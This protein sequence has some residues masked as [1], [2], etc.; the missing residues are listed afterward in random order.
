MGRPQSKHPF[1]DVA[2]TVNH[3]QPFLCLSVISA[4][5][6][7][8]LYA[9]NGYSLAIAGLWITSLLAGGLHFLSRPA[10]QPTPLVPAKSDLWLLALLLVIFA[11]FYLLFLYDLPVQLN[12]DE[13]HVLNMAKNPSVD[14][15]FDL[16]GLSSHFGNPNLIFYLVGS[17]ADGLGAMHWLQ[18]RLVNALAGL[19]IIV[20]T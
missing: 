8:G 1:G 14:G 13:V 20:F 3:I 10:E 11:P 19:L 12:T 9:V 15:K 7:C 5:A 6:G 17:L 18:F 4:A 16:F 2:K